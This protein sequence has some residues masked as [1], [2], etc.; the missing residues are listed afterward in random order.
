MSSWSGR[1]D[2]NRR[3]PEPHSG[4]NNNKIAA[5][6]K[7]SGAKQ[8]HVTKIS[9]PCFCS[10]KVLPSS[11]SC[12]KVC[13]IVY[14]SAFQAYQRTTP[15]DNMGASSTNRLRYLVSIGDIFRVTP[16]YFQSLTVAGGVT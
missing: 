2:L 7:Q 4:G 8:P 6:Q 13:P 9:A 15:Y 16:G 11:L 3:P 10:L 14:T 12:H 5:H 1:T